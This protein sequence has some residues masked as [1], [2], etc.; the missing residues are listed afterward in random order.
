[1]NGSQETE[2]D[3]NVVDRHEDDVGAVVST[4]SSPSREVQNIMFSEVGDEQCADIP[5]KNNEP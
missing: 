3:C 4:G 1:M 5:A 2:E